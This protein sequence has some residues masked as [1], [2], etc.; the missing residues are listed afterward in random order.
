MNQTFGEDWI[1]RRPVLVGMN[2][3]TSGR[4]RYALWPD[5]VGCSGWRLWK[6]LQSVS[7]ADQSQYA[8][9]FDRRNVLEG[10]SWDLGRARVQGAR[11]LAGLEDRTVLLLGR[12]TLAALALPNAPALVWQTGEG[13]RR[14]CYLPHPSG[15]NQWYNDT[16]NALLAALR[17]EQLYADSVVELGSQ[18][19][20]L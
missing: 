3:P 8:R 12:P 11:L 2:N 18:G 16:L 14:W 9:A 20:W 7:G 5:P 13:L 19:E 17:L 1:D 4:A 10:R 6:M 15:L